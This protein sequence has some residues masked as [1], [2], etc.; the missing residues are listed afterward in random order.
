M[1]LN[2]WHTSVTKMKHMNVKTTA[3]TVLAWAL[4]LRGRTCKKSLFR[5]HTHGR[6][7][8]H[9]YKMSDF[10][11]RCRRYHRF[12]LEFHLCTWTKEE[13]ILKFH[14]KG[15][16]SRV[17]EVDSFPAAALPVSK[18]VFLSEPQA[19]SR[20]EKFWTI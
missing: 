19:I 13:M 17:T 6:I 7:F 10:S 9:V 16:K 11:R 15:G 18:V 12:P 1:F 2:S 8:T 14:A 20:N 5:E 3:Y 4:K